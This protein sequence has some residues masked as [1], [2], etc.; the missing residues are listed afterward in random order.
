MARLR[1]AHTASC[2]GCPSLKW[3]VT[4]P[5]V[6]GYWTELDYG[7][8]LEYS[9]TRALEYSR[10]GQTNVTSRTC[11]GAVQPRSHHSTEVPFL[12]RCTASP[13]TRVTGGWSADADA[14]KSPGTVSAG[15]LQY[16]STEYSSYYI[17]CSSSGFGT[18]ASCKL[19]CGTLDCPSICSSSNSSTTYSTVPPYRIFPTLHVSVR[20]G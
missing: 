14:G 1:A 11:L 2:Q 16:S 4:V 8:L 10:L 15:C 6:Q 7:L 18:V 5:G 19:P 20:H 3:K 12:N 13:R 17:L 9:S